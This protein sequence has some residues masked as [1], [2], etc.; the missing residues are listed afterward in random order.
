MSV[1][2]PLVLIAILGYAGIAAGMYL[3]QRQLMYRPENKGL[4][5]EGVGLAGVQALNIATPDGENIAA[6]FAPPQSGQ[7]VVLYFHGNA[8]E[9][10]DRPRRFEFYRQHG[11][12]VLFVSYRGYGRSSGTP[13][14]D[15]L[16]ADATA[17]YEW[18]SANG[19]APKRIL[20][21]GESLGT[22]VAVRLASEK[23]VAAVALEAPYTSTT[24]IA[25]GQYW[26][27]P[28]RFLMKDR[29]ESIAR[30]AA[31]NAPLLITHGE[32]DSLIPIRYGRKLFETAR[33]PKA[34]IAWP[35]KDHDAI[36]DEDTWKTEVEFFRKHVG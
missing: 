21:V 16:A 11:F 30:I 26:W 14:E 13:T 24:D 1:L 7:P 6:W 33:E 15:G 25:A 9:I 8:G 19:A 4:T 34:F 23:P 17:A 32:A 22:G 3:M 20:L 35:G 29:Y 36:H 18:L 12:G 10:G 31:I 28:V 5:P 27:L 2:K